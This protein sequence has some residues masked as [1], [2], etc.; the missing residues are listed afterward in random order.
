MF[1]LVAGVL[2]K[3]LNDLIK[4]KKF[5]TFGMPTGSPKGN[6]LAFT[7]DIIILCKSEVRTMQLVTETLH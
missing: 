2:S 6:Y 7:N 4:D 5:R 1:I 3:A